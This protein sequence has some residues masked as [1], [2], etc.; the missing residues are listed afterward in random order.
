MLCG[1][2]KCVFLVDG[3]CEPVDGGCIGEMC[4]NWGECI[5]CQQQA[6]EDCDGMR[7]VQLQGGKAAVANVLT[8]PREQRGGIEVCQ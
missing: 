2:F 4:T 7:K 8:A 5:N 6:D 3:E 1:E